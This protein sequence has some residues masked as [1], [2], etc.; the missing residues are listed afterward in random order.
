MYVGSGFNIFGVVN[1][2]I[3]LVIFFGEKKLIIED[4]FGD[5]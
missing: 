1:L 4:T 2:I 5:P 3:G